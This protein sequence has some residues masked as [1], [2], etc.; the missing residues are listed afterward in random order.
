M[1]TYTL[2]IQREIF[3]GTVFSIGY[4]GTHGVHLNI[5]ANWDACS[6]TSIDSNGYFIRKYGSTP[7][8]SYA[9]AQAG[10]CAR[11]NPNFSQIITTFPQG[12][13]HY[14]ALQV[15]V[16]H[17][18]A[19]GLTFQ[20][21]YTWS[22]CQS[23]GD[24]YTGGDSVNVGSKGGS[25][26]GQLPGINANVRGNLY[27]YAPC[28]FNLDQQL[29][30]NIMYQFP[31][32]GSRLKE[33]WQ[34]ALIETFHTGF[35]TTPLVGVDAA[36]CGFNGCAGID[37]PNV[38]PGCN[39]YANQSIKNWYNVSCFTEPIGEFGNSGLSTIKG[40]LFSQFDLSLQKTTRL[41]ESKS[42]NLRADIFNFVNHPNMDFP[43]F[44]LFTDINGTRNP[45]G[46]QITTTGSYAQREIQ[47]SATFK[48]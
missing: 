19:K 13:S 2:N 31:F 39:L 21:A 25:A 43:T 1:E 37:R 14:N 32:T 8:L 36:N 30:S 17:T 10:N 44:S 12:F 38:T 42:F 4:T 5:A 18:L 28:A 3:P 11:P 20:A 33:G 22:R 41:T 24:E 6:P 27:D 9:A 7:A 48:F 15:S 40:P 16:A 34:I 23:I 47:L 45:L 46:S 26:G 35:L 29:N